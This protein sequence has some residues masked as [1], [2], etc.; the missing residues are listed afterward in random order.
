MRI[1]K[2]GILFS[3]LLPALLFSLPVSAADIP[4]SVRY[5]KIRAAAT[6]Y[7][8]DGMEVLR[9]A[10]DAIQ[11]GNYR[12]TGI[13]DLWTTAL[14]EG[15]S[16]FGTGRL[17][18]VTGPAKTGDMLGQ[19]TIGPWQITAQT[20]QNY[21]TTDISPKLQARI[22]A[23]L[24][25][26]SYDRLGKRAPLAI[27]SYFWLEAFE[28]KRIGQGPWYNSVLAKSPAEMKNTG[29][30]AKQIIL[31]SRFNSRGLLYWLHVTG[32]EDAIRDVLRTWSRNGYPI[33]KEDLQHCDCDVEFRRHLLRLLPQRHGD[34]ERK[35]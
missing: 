10:Y 1:T 24:I 13:E 19:T 14:Q 7:G 18:S 35:D 4:L 2:A 16:L 17:W 25:E 32:D 30:Y 15:K 23:D 11:N 8:K 34:T 21:K 27:Q 29:F 22:A 6:D 3:A 28:Q 20:L 5:E 9:I 31:G 26:K 33:R 12:Q